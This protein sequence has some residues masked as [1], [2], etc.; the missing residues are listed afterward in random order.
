MKTIHW[1]RI[2]RD[3]KEQMIDI[4]EL[5]NQELDEILSKEQS[6]QWIRLTIGN[7]VKWI[8]ENMNDETDKLIQYVRAYKANVEWKSDSNQAKVVVAR[9][10]LSE[11]T[12]ER[13]SM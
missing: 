8:K 3:G 13:I 7:L 10:A 6:K 1:F 11:E 9:Q 5:T 4:L 12:K 2:M